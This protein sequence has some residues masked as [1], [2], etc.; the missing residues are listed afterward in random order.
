M[1]SKIWR[2]YGSIRHKDLQDWAATWATDEIFAG[3]FSPVGAED[4]WWLTALLVERLKL[5]GLDLTGG[6]TDIHKCFDQIM[7]SLLY[8][9]VED[10]HFPA[11][12]LNA[13][14]SFHEESWYYDTLAGA[15]GEAHQHPCGIPQGCP[16]SML[17]VAFM[18]PPWVGLMKSKNV[19][20][21]LRTTSSSSLLA[22]AMK[23]VLERLT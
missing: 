2:L 14:R 15:L 17:I 11:E 22:L 9:H 3:I 6:S 19:E 20:P 5:E 21:H 18:M 10:A 8:R 16:L 12:I 23:S 1:L 13:Y 4:A 7:R